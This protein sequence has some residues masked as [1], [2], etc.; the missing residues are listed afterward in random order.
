MNMYQIVQTL[1]VG[2]STIT[3][4]AFKYSKK[5]NIRNCEEKILET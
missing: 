3:I 2:M 4:H 1:D 5:Y